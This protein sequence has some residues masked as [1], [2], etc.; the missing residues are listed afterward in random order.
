[1]N[2]RNKLSVFVLAALTAASASSL[3]EAQPAQPAQPSAPAPDPTRRADALFQEG[4]ILLEQGRF[5]EACERLAQSETIDPTVSTLGLLAGCH[6][7]QGRIA[8]AWKEYLATAKRAEAVNDSRAEFARQRAEALAPTLP[9]LLVRLSGASPD[10]E[11]Y[12]NLDRIP[13]EELGVEIAV[14]PGAYEIVARSPK[15][16]EF[17]MTITAREGSKVLVDVPDLRTFSEGSAPAAAPHP[18]SNAVSKTMATPR[19]TPPRAEPPESGPSG[20]VK[21]AAVTSAIGL[22]GVA[23]GAMFGI[24]AVSKSNESTIIQ[25]TCKSAADSAAECQ[26]GKALRE[27]AYGASTAATI[28]FGVGAAGLGAGLIILLIPS[29]NS[30]A[31]SNSGATPSVQIAPIASSDGGGAVLSGR[32]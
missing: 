25:A 31:P 15:R 3:A 6:E 16:Q 12:R 2:G 30:S 22:T 24:S 19:P 20:R 17:R 11:I 14:D 21:A 32:F 29:G 18:P 4:K 8:T 10:I 27:S 28:S 5:G 9:K 13:A 7:Q 1:V 26:R 23:L